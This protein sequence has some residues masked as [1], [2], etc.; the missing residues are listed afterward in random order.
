MILLIQPMQRNKFSSRFIIYSVLLSLWMASGCTAIK[1]DRP[2]ENYYPVSYAPRYST[3]NIPLEMDGKILKK[4]INRE[5]TGVIYNDDSYDNNNRDLLMIKATRGDSITLSIERNQISYRVPLKIWLSKKI[6]TS[7]LGYTYATHAEARADLALKFKTTVSIN[8]DWSFN[9]LTQSDGYEWITT[10]TLQLGGVKIPL[11]LIT[12][13]LVNSNLPLITREVDKALKDNLNLRSVMSEVWNQIQQPLLVSPENSLWLKIDPIEVST[14]PIRGNT[15]SL[16]HVV[17]LKALVE[18]SMGDQPSVQMNKSLPPLKITSALS[19]EFAVN[20]SMDIPFT[21]INEKARQS[22]LGYTYKY[23]KYT[24][25]VMDI[26]LYGQ[27][28]NLIVAI[29]VEGSIQ[30]TIYLAGKPVFREENMTIGMENLD[31]SISTKNV[32]VKT[33]SWIFKSGLLQKLESNLVF[34]IGQ[35]LE[36][37]RVELNSYLEKGLAEGYFKI[38]GSVGRLDIDKLLVA[39]GSVKAYFQFEGKVK[40]SMT[41]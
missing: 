1:I 18:L 33:G 29:G 30:G 4:I 24:I 31:F 15:S 34:P 6:E 9:T 8:S 13:V 35:N 19:D 23:S 20:F 12:D 36:N 37:A 38:D 3:I 14:I 10:P 39:P 26:S 27:G 21:L 28:E 16:K 22:F 25:R 41:L 7:L 2:A 40:V 32:L 11:P 5:I 17:G